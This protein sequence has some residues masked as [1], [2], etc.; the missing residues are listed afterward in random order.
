MRR[1]HVICRN[2]RQMRVA[3]CG[4]GDMGMVHVETLSALPGIEVVA[5][6]DPV[7]DRAAAAARRGLKVYADAEEMIDTVKAD[8]V[9]IATPTCS[10]AAL[11]TRAL[12]R[13][14]HVFCEK[15]MARRVDEGRAMLDAARESGRTLAIGFT[16]R[17]NEAYRAAR[18]AVRSGKLGRIGTVRTSRCARMAAAWHAD[19]A[20]NGGAAFELLSH[21]L[22]WLNWTFGR[23]LRIFARGLSKGK[24]SVEGD[25]TLA[26]LRMADGTIAHLEGSLAEVGEFH[27]SYEIAGS[28]GLLAYDTRR[29]ATLEGKFVTETGIEV[30]SETPQSNRPFARQMRA[31]VDSVTSGREFEVPCEDALTALELAAAVE[32][33]TE[34]ETVVEPAQA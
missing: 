17:F 6:A 29:S 10:H 2:G 3:V 9:S 15:P 26:V 20:G 32:K 12:S 33:S 22:D 1:R 18:E 7:A 11:A 27:A 13:G 25:Y 14:A 16:L 30:I 21:D 23:P 34:T 28:G 4:Y 5:V 8:V 19:V 31:F 24:K